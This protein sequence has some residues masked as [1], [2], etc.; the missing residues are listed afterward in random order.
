MIW[1]RHTRQDTRNA[2]R[3][4][5]TITH[6]WEIASKS[7]YTLKSFQEAQS[8]LNSF[9]ACL[10]NVTTLSKVLFHIS[11]MVLVH[12]RPQINVA[13]EWNTSPT[14]HTSLKGHNSANMH[15][16]LKWPLMISR[17][18]TFANAFIPKTYNRSL[19][20]CTSPDYNSGNAPQFPHWTSPYTF[21]I[22]EDILL[23]VPHQA[24]SYA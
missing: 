11:P 9:S 20:G 15:R 5:S 17:I 12:Y 16:D 1:H 22:T 19:L 2:V 3:P 21:A 6:I 8:P 13:L 14:S 18:L 4:G 7:N 23:S 24:Y 10:S